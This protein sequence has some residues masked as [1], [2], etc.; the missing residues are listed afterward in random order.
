FIV[1]SKTFTT[2][3]TMT[4]A[5]SARQWLLAG[6]GGEVK[7]VAKHFVAV[8]TNARKVSEFGI[9][10]AN[11]FG[12]W[13]WV[14]ALFHGLGDRPVDGA[15]RRS[16]QLS[17]AARRVPPDGRALPDRPVRAQP[18]GAPGLA[19]RVVHGFLRRRNRG[20]LALR[21]IP[22]ALPRL[23]AAA[24]DGEQRQARRARW[25]RDRLCDRAHLL[26]RAGHQ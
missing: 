7:A 4:N 19:D 26:G 18:A 24:D 2:L 6:L 21:A 25:R 3:E 22:Q 12:F 10:T 20:G 5:E 9:D 17:R 23:P 15:R 1:S 11:M 16:R 8:S 14:G 13:D